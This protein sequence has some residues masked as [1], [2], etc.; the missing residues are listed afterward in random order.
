MSVE[1]LKKAT[2]NP[3]TGE[4]KT[5]EIVVNMLDDIMAHQVLIDPGSAA[6]IL[7]KPRSHLHRRCFH[8]SHG[9]H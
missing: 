4:T 5:R 1:Y 7:W 6:L 9:L 2:K 3:E 8:R